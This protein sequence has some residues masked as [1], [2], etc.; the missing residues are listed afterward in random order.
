MKKKMKWVTTIGLLSGALCCLVIGVVLRLAP[1][2]AIAVLLFLLAGMAA[3]REVRPYGRPVKN[4]N[5]G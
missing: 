1:L 4:E 5:R 2:M 3:W